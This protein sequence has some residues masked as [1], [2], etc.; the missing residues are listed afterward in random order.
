MIINANYWQIHFAVSAYGDLYSGMLLTTIE[1]ILSSGVKPLISVYWQDIADDIIIPFQKAYG[2]K[3]RFICTTHDLEGDQVTRIS[4]KTLIWEQ[5]VAEAPDIPLVLLDGDTLVTGETLSFFDQ[6][7]DVGFTVKDEKW[8]INTGVMLVKHPERALSFFDEWRQRTVEIIRS[9]ELFARANSPDF[10]YGGSDQMSF[11]ELVKYEKGRE[12]YLLKSDK[13]D[14]TFKTFPC[15]VLNETRSVP[16]SESTRIYHFKGGWRSILT[17]GSPFTKN[18][19]KKDG[20]DMY[21]L[22]LRTFLKASNK[23]ASIVDGLEIKRLG[24][25]IPWYL[26]SSTLK[27]RRGIYPIYFFL[28]LSRKAVSSFFR[29]VFRI[30]SGLEKADLHR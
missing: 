12:L 20:F 21:T 16:L 6:D 17:E 27:E 30:F 2:D 9:P 15:R 26:D 22:Y 3:C 10:P 29:I 4:M 18:R 25:V 14:L 13:L 19:P 7:F 8:P 24:I 11:Y 28:F 1:S 5:A 23:L